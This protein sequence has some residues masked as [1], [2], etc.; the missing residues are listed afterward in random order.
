MARTKEQN[1]KMRT[2]KKELILKEALKQFS[3]KGLF[4]TK[5]KDIAEGVGMA[6]G[7]LYNYYKSKEEIYTE[8]VD[9]ALNK[10]N[11]AM[12]MLETMEDA[13]HEKIRKSIIQLLKTIEGSEEFN[14]TCRFIAQA[15]NSSAIPQEARKSIELKRDKPYESISNIIK[16]GQI[17]GTIVEGDP[18]QLAVLFWTSIN[19]LAIYKATRDGNPTIPQAEMLI[20]IFLKE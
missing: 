15:T 11:D 1:E 13:P 5:I 18:Y 19:G 6:Q 16:Q 9:N 2:E 12:K 7:L 8:L 10:M 3:D 14:Q 17:D 20:R 4:A